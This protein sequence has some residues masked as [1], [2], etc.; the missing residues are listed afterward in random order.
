[1]CGY[2]QKCLDSLLFPTKCIKMEITPSQNCKYGFIIKKKVPSFAFLV[3]L[4]REA[5]R[6]IDG[7]CIYMCPFQG[8]MQVTSAAPSS[9]SKPPSRWDRVLGYPPPKTGNPPIPPAVGDNSTLG[10]V[11]G[12]PTPRLTE[13]VDTSL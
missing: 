3:F 8:H 6:G 11:R 1:M 13:R 2:E 5:I 7:G 10:G 4:V 9:C 12:L